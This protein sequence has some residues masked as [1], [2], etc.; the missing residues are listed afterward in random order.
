MSAAILDTAIV[1][2]G[3]NVVSCSKDGTAKLWDVGQQRCLGTFTD[4]GGNVNCCSL[5]VIDS[6]ITLE[7]PRT[8]PSNETSI[9]IM[10]HIY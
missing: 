9:V 1:D 8:Q 6:A 10:Y 5:G 7:Q 2:R 4:I 3:R